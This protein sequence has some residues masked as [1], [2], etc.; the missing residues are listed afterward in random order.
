MINHY[1]MAP[2]VAS[3]SFSVL[4]YLIS[5]PVPGVLDSRQ[6]DRWQYVQ[7]ALLDDALS[8]LGQISKLQQRV[9]ELEL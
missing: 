8:A 7:H 1:E 5:S 9:T 6:R 2:S 4:S 3:D